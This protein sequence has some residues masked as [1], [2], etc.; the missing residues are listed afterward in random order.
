MHNFQNGTK[1]C[2]HSFEDN[3]DYVMDVAWSPEHPAMF[4]SADASGR[5]DLWNL[6]NDV[7]VR[8]KI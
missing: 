6:N 5:I 8:W 2:L 7:E 1:K 4:A 3:N